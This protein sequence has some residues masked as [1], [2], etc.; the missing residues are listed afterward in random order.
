MTNRITVYGHLGRDAEIKDINGKRVLEL[1]I[2]S[3]HK[4]KGEEISVWR[5]VTFWDDNYRNIEPYLK[6]GS[7]LIVSG[8][9]LPASV[10]QSNT[11]HSVS[12]TMTGKDIMFSPFGK[13][14]SDKGTSPQV[15]SLVQPV[16]EE[17]R[18]PGLPPC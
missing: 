1:S 12:L 15:V 9:E 14:S 5:K 18:L 7:A 13:G 10:Y 4:I 16:Q 8:E 17:P 6:K 11:G 3:N 2:A